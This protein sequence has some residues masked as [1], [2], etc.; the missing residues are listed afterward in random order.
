M[1]L[2]LTSRLIMPHLLDCVCR[3]ANGNYIWFRLEVLLPMKDKL[4]YKPKPPPGQT[5]N[6]V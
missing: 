5:E 6:L 1:A 2:V 4:I 3:D